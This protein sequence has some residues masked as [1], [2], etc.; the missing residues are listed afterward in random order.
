MHKQK[1][2]GENGGGYL[3]NLHLNK[4]EKEEKKERRV[5]ED[6]MVR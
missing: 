3:G 1:K 4:A 6:E 5:V 2:K